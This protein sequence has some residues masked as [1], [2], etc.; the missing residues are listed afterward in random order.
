MFWE[1]VFVMDFLT[2]LSREC[3]L[4]LLLNDKPRISISSIFWGFLNFMVF[5]SDFRYFSR[6]FFF[7]R[8]WHPRQFIP[9]VCPLGCRM[10]AKRV[11]P[12]WT[13]QFGPQYR[14]QS[15]GQYIWKLNNKRPRHWRCQYLKTSLYRYQWGGLSTGYHFY[16]NVAWVLVKLIFMGR[17]PDS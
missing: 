6:V 1:K 15:R 11:A 16:E 10:L 2:F 5:L 4:I 14:P 13:A 17:R 7:F 3:E 8:C 12:I 9:R